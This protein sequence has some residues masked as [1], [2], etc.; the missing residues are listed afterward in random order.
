MTVTIISRHSR[1]IQKLVREQMQQEIEELGFDP[2]G[3]VA[4]DVYEQRVMDLEQ[5]SFKNSEI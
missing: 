4:Q 3:D 1:S 2:F 5:E